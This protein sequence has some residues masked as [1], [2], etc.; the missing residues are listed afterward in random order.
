MIPG[1]RR[2]RRILWTAASQPPEMVI[3]KRARKGNGES[4]NSVPPLPFVFSNLGGCEAAPRAFVALDPA[5]AIVTRDGEVGRIIVRSV[6][7]GVMKDDLLAIY[8]GSSRY[9]DS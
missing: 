6:V 4:S 9:A 8:P 1:M 7:I 5:M 3:H 2:A